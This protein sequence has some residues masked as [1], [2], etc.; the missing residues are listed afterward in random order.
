MGNACDMVAR[1]EG[2]EEG[3]DGKIGR[4]KPIGRPRKRRMDG[5]QT[6]TKELL[7]VKNWKIQVG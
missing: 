4:S 3:Y 6:D 2:T 7:K 1:R 5:I